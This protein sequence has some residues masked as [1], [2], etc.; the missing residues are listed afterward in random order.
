MRGTS[1]WKYSFPFPYTCTEKRNNLFFIFNCSQMDWKINWQKKKLQA[2]PSFYSKSSH[3]NFLLLQTH[4]KNRIYVLISEFFT[5]M[6]SFALYSYVDIT[7]LMGDIEKT[8]QKM[9]PFCSIYQ[10]VDCIFRLSIHSAAKLMTR[11]YKC[12]RQCGKQFFATKQTE[13]WP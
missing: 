9:D 5:M 11:A 8:C 4:F 2:I 1:F 6:T 13:E 10:H 3:K 7:K 12:S